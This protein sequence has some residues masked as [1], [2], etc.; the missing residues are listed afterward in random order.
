MTHLRA[1]LLSVFL[2]SAI[3]AGLPAKADVVNGSFENFFASW[4]T[5]G[6]NTATTN[7]AGVLPT[8]GQRL[9]YLNNGQGALP[10]FVQSFIVDNNLGLT[11]GSFSNLVNSVS[12]N[13]TEGAVLFQSFDLN[14]GNNTLL[15]DWNF[16]TNENA[17]GTQNNDFGMYALLDGSNSLV[18]SGAV[19]VL[20]SSFMPTPTGSPFAEQTGWSTVSIG[21]LNPGSNYTLIFG[22]FDDATTTVNSG[23]LI[24]N[25]RSIPEPSAGLLAG[26]GLLPFLRRRSRQAD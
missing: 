3:F 13:A 5:S 23:L 7:V 10:L 18:S 16:L 21:G 20:N 22:V 19:D 2:L 25:V 15:F 26:L 6:P 9:A 4:T 12:P 1:K 8:D 24:D 14:L 11:A 17:V